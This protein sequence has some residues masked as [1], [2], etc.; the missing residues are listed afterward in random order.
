MTEQESDAAATA[1][2]RPHRWFAWVWMVPIIAGAIVVWLGARSFVMHGPDIT[3]SF[4]NAEGLTE[5]QSFIRHRGVTVGRV[6]E[7]ELA[8]DMSRVIVHARMSRSAKEALNENTRFYIVSPRVGVEGISGLSTIVSGVYI[9]MEPAAGSKVQTAFTG[10]EEPPLIRPDTAGRSFTM[11]A[12]DLGSLTRGSSI[13]YHDV[14]V[15]EVQG[16]SLDPDGQRVTVTAFIRSP[17][18]RLVHPETRFWNAGGVD[19]TVGT[20]G[21]HV[22]ANSWQQ[23][24]SGGVAFDTPV[25]A[26]KGTPSPQGA[27]FTLYDT[28]REAR[29]DPRG[30]ELVYVAGFSGNLRGVEKGAPVELEGMQIGVVRDVQL[31]YESGKKTLT[32]LV[33]IAIDPERVQILNMPGPNGETPSQ[34]AQRKIETLVGHGMRA[35]V[36]TANF[37]TGFE[38]VTLDM[39]PGA[40]PGRIEHVDGYVKIPTEASSDIGATLQSLRNVLANL[41]RA[42]SGPELGHAIRSLDSALTHLDQLTSDVRPDLQS[43]LKS[44]RETSDSANATLNSLRSVVGG[45]GGGAAGSTDVQQ[46]MQQLS[47]AARSVRGLADYLERHPESLIRGRRGDK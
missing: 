38:I 32:T 24:I 14:S 7:I 12:P 40:K 22:R 19:L 23:V 35:Q 29:R 8:P 6:E 41:D 39:V 30:E 20:Q 15:G 42:T 36:L 17:Y 27:M 9:E 18:D 4:K 31:S 3:I 5:R 11:W 37:L 28:E 25:E 16:F 10:L 47:E 13:T 45:Q 26:L 44:L 2:A 33:T 46:L 43:L 21:L 1:R 34:S